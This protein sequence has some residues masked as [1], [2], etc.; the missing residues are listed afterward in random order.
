MG[1]KVRNN[2]GCAFKLLVVACVQQLK[3]YKTYVR[4]LRVKTA[5]AL[6][7]TDARPVTT[8]IAELDSEHHVNPMTS[9]A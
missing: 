2:Y 3:R 6:C 4:L 5:A 7:E 9:P 8:M 1:M